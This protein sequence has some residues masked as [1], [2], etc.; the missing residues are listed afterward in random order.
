MVAGHIREVVVLY[1]NNCIGTS[2]ADSELVVS[3]EWLSCRSLNKF[4]C[5]QDLKKSYKGKK[6]TFCR[7]R[8]AF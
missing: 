2:W 7:Q 8:I 3:D 5:I 1:S 6:R 4:D